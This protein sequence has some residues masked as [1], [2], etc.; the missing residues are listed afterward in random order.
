MPRYERGSRGFESLSGYLWRI[1]SIGGTSGSQPGGYGFEPRMRYA[2]HG[3]LAQSAEASLSKGEG[4]GF[5]SRR[6]YAIQVWPVGVIGS[7]PDFHSGVCGFEP[8]TGYVCR[9]KR[10][11]LSEVLRQTVKWEARN[12]GPFVGSLLRVHHD[13]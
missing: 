5:E 8:R 12:A 1:S 2:I 6:G 11:S 4:S 7:S 13:G 10:P 9:C 3:R